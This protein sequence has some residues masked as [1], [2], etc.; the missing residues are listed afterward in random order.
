MV[1]IREDPAAEARR[2]ARDHDAILAVG[3]AATVAA[4]DRL[5]PAPEPEA[6]RL[7]RLN[8]TL[9]RAETVQARTRASAAAHLARTLNTDLAIHPATL[10]RAAA[11]LLVASAEL[12][13]AEAGRSG[14]GG[15]RATR[16]RWLV[17]LAIVVAGIGVAATTSR[18]I[19]LAVMALGIVSA[20]IA[21][22]AI[23]RMARVMV[24]DLIM[25][26]AAARRRWEQLAGPGADPGDVDAVVHRYDPRQQIV[27]DLVG[28]SPAVRAADRAVRIQR[29][30]WVQAWCEAV[31]DHD[32]PEE[33]DPLVTAVSAVGALRGRS[34][35]ELVISAP[36]AGLS[37]QS[38]RLLHHRLLRVPDHQRVIVVLRS[39]STADGGP[40]VDLTDPRETIDVRDPAAAL[41]MDLGAAAEADQ[42]K[43]EPQPQVR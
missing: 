32:E 41:T 14:T 23:R 2:Y 35:R 10:V 15:R 12:A 36:Y 5:M 3:G 13:D 1:I 24:P 4:L 43:E 19:G 6:E 18:P 17:A 25:D 38:A 22:L 31:G 21:H 42:L 37:D 7:D 29:T 20:L 27:A 8:A 26:E 34:R 28:H 39:D 16:L 40:I 9:R 30:A 11:E 33:P